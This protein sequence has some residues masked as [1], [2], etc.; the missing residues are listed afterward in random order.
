M[1]FS[2]KK[3]IEVSEGDEEEKEQ[4]PTEFAK[5][6]AEA[7]AEEK[8][9]EKQMYE[10]A[11]GAVERK[12]AELL[13][14]KAERQAAEAVAA[15]AASGTDVV[16]PAHE[17]AVE[18]ER[19]KVVEESA[20]HAVVDKLARSGMRFADQSAESIVR[21]L[22]DPMM[23]PTPPATAPPPA[24]FE[25]S[26]VWDGARVGKV[27]KRGDHGTGYY[28]DVTAA[29][30]AA[31]PTPTASAAPPSGSEVMP[32]SGSEVMSAEVEDLDE[33]D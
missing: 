12:R 24:S 9:T 18:Y 13:R 11:L 30:P 3:A 21:A 16:A 6:Q 29:T 25:P 17:E 20:E 14:L 7:L 4:S 2:G 28:E 27:F 23:I 5:R 10:R 33:L 31:A 15:E 8:M 1:S 32:S 19:A 26:E 22:E